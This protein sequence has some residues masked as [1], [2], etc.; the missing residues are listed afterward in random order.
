M[1]QGQVNCGVYGRAFR[2]NTPFFCVHIVA[3]NP[4]HLPATARFEVTELGDA[5]EHDLA[6]ACQGLGE[7]GRQLPVHCAARLFDQTY[8][9]NLSVSGNTVVFTDM[10][11]GSSSAVFRLGCAVP[12]LPQPLE[13]GTNLV[14]HLRQT[15]IETVFA[16]Y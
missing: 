4:N 7:P 13:A 2:E 6:A 15:N 16:K 1:W 12:E 10:I 3:V 8:A 11:A 9:V 5:S 14:Y